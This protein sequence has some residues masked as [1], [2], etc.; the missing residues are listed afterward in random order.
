MLKWQSIRVGSLG[1]TILLLLY[2][3]LNAIL[4]ELFEFQFESRNVVLCET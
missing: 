3:K 2:V 1:R 4:E